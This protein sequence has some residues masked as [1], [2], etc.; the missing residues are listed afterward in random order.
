MNGIIDENRVREIIKEELANY[1][2]PK[3]KRGPNKWQLFLK[4][5][6]K[7]QPEE[8]D[9]MGKVKACSIIYKDN[10]NPNGKS[11]NGVQEQ[12]SIGISPNAVK[13][14]IPNGISPNSVQNKSQIQK[15]EIK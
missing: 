5:C 7:D 10:K 15:P 3:K 8:F 13:E 1:N 4:D 14:E 2:P 9:Y 6:V 12:K 11:P